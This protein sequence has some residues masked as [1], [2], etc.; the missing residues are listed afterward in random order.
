M[1]KASLKHCMSVAEDVP[2]ELRKIDEP[3]PTIPTGFD[4]TCTIGRVSL[5]NRAGNDTP[6][7][8]ALYV[9]ADHGATGVYCFKFPESV[10]GGPQNFRVTVEP[11]E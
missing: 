7:Q 10:V 5:T 1:E 4:I 11:V 9:I 8:A 2:F 6:L 3:F